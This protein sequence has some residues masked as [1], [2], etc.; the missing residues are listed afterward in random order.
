MKRII[1]EF[2]DFSLVGVTSF[3]FQLFLTV[4]LTEVFGIWYRVAYA[5]G[6]FVS[7][8]Y[9]FLLNMKLTFTA[10]DKPLLRLERFIAVAAVIAFLNWSA[11]VVL[12][13]LIGA[14][15]IISII[16]ISTL[17]GILNFEM[18]EV[19]VFKKIPKSVHHRIKKAI[20][21]KHAKFTKDVIAGAPR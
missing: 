20:H 21:D 16:V 5:A 4:F 13:E 8:G 9:Q 10:T 14:N 2:L 17:M 6:L 1:H 15:Y 7:Y 11:V 19:W 18:E 3:G 12:T